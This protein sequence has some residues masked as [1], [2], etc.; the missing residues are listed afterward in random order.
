MNFSVARR[1]LLALVMLAAPFAPTQALIVDVPSDVPPNS[2]IAG[3]NPVLIPLT[4][5]TWHVTPVGTAAGGAFDAWN[6]WGNVSGCD[7]SGENCTTGWLHEYQISSAEIGSEFLTAGNI[8]QTPALA[9]ANSLGT[10]FSLT[11]DQIVSFQILD[12]DTINNQGGVSL[13]L[14]TVPE[15]AS[16]ALLGFGLVGLG[17]ARRRLR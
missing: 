7:G 2:V 5:G 11:L 14:E 9:L 13:R 15:P 3:P 4:A 12:S 8:Y 17:F 6:A 16:L 1:L 10:T